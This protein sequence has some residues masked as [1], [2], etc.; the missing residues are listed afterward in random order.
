MV[1]IVLVLLTEPEAQ[2]IIAKAIPIYKSLVSTQDAY[3]DK[4]KEMTWAK[5]AWWETADAFDIELA[6]NHECVRIVRPYTH[7]DR[8]DHYVDLIPDWSLFLAP[9]R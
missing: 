8:F 3:P 5:Q 9:S 7:L 1:N 6:P 4:M 2:H